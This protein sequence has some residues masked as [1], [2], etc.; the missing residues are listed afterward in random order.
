MLQQFHTQFCSGYFSNV[1]CGFS[2]VLESLI[3]RPYSS[4]FSFIP[5]FLAQISQASTTVILRENATVL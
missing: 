2:H 4:F 5:P 3:Q 1:S